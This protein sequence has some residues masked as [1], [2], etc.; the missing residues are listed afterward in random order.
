[1]SFRRHQRKRIHK[2]K[3][4]GNQRSGK[5]HERKCAAKNQMI[6]QFS[7]VDWDKSLSNTFFIIKCSAA[8][9][10]KI[11]RNWWARKKHTAHLS[12]VWFDFTRA[13]QI[14]SSS[15]FSHLIHKHT[16]SQRRTRMH[17]RTSHQHSIL[18]CRRRRRNTFSALFFVC[19]VCC[20]RLFFVYFYIKCWIFVVSRQHF[21][22]HAHASGYDMLMS[23]NVHT[24]DEN[25]STIKTKLQKSIKSDEQNKEEK[26][27]KNTENKQTKYG[28][29]NIF[30]VVVIMHTQ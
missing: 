9:D 12:P 3:C 22:A 30:S 19:C 1:M 8:N 14:R 6:L 20:W 16:H 29:C 21:R 13:M 10:R 27:E 5:E 28:K 26:E 25:E 2:K 4:S 18:L 24:N 11:K 15:L 23:K 17:A 7:R